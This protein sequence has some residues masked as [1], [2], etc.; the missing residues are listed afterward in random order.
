MNGLSQD[1]I[2]IDTNVFE[3]LLNPQENVDGHIG[4]LLRKL[5]KDKIHLLVDDK[6]RIRKEYWNRLNS[7]VQKERVAEGQA[8]RILLIYWFSAANQE[9]VSVKQ[10]DAL[11]KAIQNIIHEKRGKAVTDRFYVYIAFKKGRILVTN[12]N[13][14]IVNRR[15]QLRQKTRKARPNGADIMTSETAHSKL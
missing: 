4:D 2:A 5:S 13:K 15:G 6:K 1:S 7:Y 11:M 9:V 10:N 14:D 3:H 12:D 8:E